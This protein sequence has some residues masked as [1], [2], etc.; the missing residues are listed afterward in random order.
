MKGILCC[1]CCSQGLTLPNELSWELKDCLGNLNFG[2]DLRSKVDSQRTLYELT[3][4]NFSTRIFQP[5][6]QHGIIRECL[7]LYPE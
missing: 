2:N 7:N 3:P 1:V 4:Q 5:A 6:I